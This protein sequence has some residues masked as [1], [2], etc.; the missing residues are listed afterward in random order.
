V[1]KLDSLELELKVVS[2]LTEMLEIELKTSV[3]A[4]VILKGLWGSNSAYRACVPRSYPWS[5]V[6]GLAFP[7]TF[8]YSFPITHTL[9]K[10]IHIKEELFGLER[11][12]SG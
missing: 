3:R 9:Q 12:L 11:W 2:H 10:C 5:Y 1:R 4:K 8:F 6:I 7:K